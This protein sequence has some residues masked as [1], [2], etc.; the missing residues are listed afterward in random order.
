LLLKH[1]K[2][3]WGTHDSTFISFTQIEAPDSENH[4]KNRDECELE[5]KWSQIFLVSLENQV[6][7][8]T[9]VLTLTKD[10]DNK[11]VII[12]VKPIEMKISHARIKQ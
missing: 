4:F 8:E 10:L 2:P 3:V 5:V 1:L 9:L 7:E 6:L 12:G 11:N